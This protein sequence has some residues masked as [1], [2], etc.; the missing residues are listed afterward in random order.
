[1]G[2]KSKVSVADL[3]NA[4]S[5]W[6][7]SSRRPVIKGGHAPIESGWMLCDATRTELRDIPVP[8]VSGHSHS[9]R[10][11]VAYGRGIGKGVDLAEYYKL[12]SRMKVKRK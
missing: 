11:E 2:V 9:H 10:S 6:Q 4:H 1:M 5:K 8:E 7:G 3:R 12:R